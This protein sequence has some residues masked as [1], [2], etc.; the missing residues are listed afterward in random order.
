VRQIGVGAVIARQHRH[1]N[2]A[3]AQLP[4]GCKRDARSAAAL[5][6]VVVDDDDA[7][8]D[9]PGRVIGGR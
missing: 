1:G 9:G 2:L 7:L 5:D 8:E 3:R 4:D 6:T